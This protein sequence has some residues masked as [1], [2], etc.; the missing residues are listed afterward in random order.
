MPTPNDKSIFRFSTEA[1]PER[2]R[3]TA[4]REVFGRTVV[5][6]DIQPLAL[7][8]FRSEATV[9]G[10]PGLGLL[11]GET[12]AV[13]L[14]H[15]AN[16]I[17][18]DDLSFAVGPGGAWAACQLGRTATL[19]A[20]D[21]VLMSNAVVGSMTLPSACR[22]MTFRVPVAAIQRLV[23]DVAAKVA[24][25]LPVQSPALQL[26][27]RYLGIFRDA[28]AEL[29]P[30]LQRAAVTHVYDLLALTLGATR[31]GTEIASARGLPAVR[32]RA[33]KADIVENLGRAELS[34]ATLAA[35][36]GITPRYVQMLFEQDGMTFTEFVRE[37][38]LSRA[39]RLLADPRYANH[40]IGAIAYE[41][42]FGDL[43]YFN[44]A[45]RRQFGAT[46]SDIR[47]TTADHTA[48]AGRPGSPSAAP[49]GRE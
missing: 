21:G 11:V 15:S 16:L 14:E 23:P 24:T 46:P 12:S 43:S 22:F 44:K 47:A 5:S 20:G 1:Y 49:N 13:H 41:V 26:L 30:E 4:W 18:D 39:Y 17:V 25:R 8:G 19:G 45:F 10:L 36:H 29:T 37:Q 2:D 32:L 42:G 27:S 7:D 6:L 28:P 35:R 9:C 33:I 3:L 31:E 40:T 48:S 38:R 34:A